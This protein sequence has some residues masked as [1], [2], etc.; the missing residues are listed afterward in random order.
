MIY[1]FGHPEWIADLPKPDLFAYN[2]AIVIY[3]AGMGGALASHALTQMG[4]RF[5]AYV[6][7]DVN[8]HGHVYYEHIILSPEQLYEKHQDA[9]ILIASV[10]YGPIHDTLISI[11][12]TNEQIFPSF[13]ILE[14]TDFNDLESPWSNEYIFRSIKRATIKILRHMNVSMQ[15]YIEAVALIPTDKCTLKCR[16]CSNH[17]PYVENPMDYDLDKMVLSVENIVK[18]GYFIGD[19]TI[20]SAE[21][22]LYKPL[23]T[24]VNSLVSIPNIESIYIVSNATLMPSNELLESLRNDKV[25]VRLSN[26]GELSSKFNDLIALF[27]ENHIRFEETNR[28]SFWKYIDW[29]THIDEP[30]Q[31]Q[32]RYNRCTM[33]SRSSSLFTSEGKAYLCLSA[34]F[35]D[36]RGWIDIPENERVDLLDTSSPI[37]PKLDALMNR[38]NYHT[39]CRNCL[40]RGLSDTLERVPVA[41]QL[42]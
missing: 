8:K 31:L 42:P 16:D 37:R 36:L 28:I 20:N 9:I 4:L 6:D 19:V 39:A 14:G 1:R 35:L 22:F 10:F 5:L 11:G 12:F 33:N 7:S 17:V 41:V 27:K 34:N 26:Y 3:G 32:E 30:K 38:K 23:P 21:P 25:I 18:A 2:A 13:L 40:S 24:L 15:G 29:K